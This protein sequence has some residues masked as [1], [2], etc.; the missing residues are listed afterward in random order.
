MPRLFST[1]TS[2]LPLSWGVARRMVSVVVVLPISKNTLRGKEAGRGHGSVY[3]AR[4][5]G[6]LCSPPSSPPRSY[7]RRFS[8]PRPAQAPSSRPC[9][10]SRFPPSPVVLIDVLPVLGP[11]HVGC[12]LAQD[13][14][15][16]LH[17][18]AFARLRV[19]WSLLNFRRD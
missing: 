1:Y 2:Y 11:A 6:Q 13:L 18:G 10:C 19:I 5:I 9:P 15:S 12:W 14:C 16:Q 8:W 4:L 17:R 7:F 3:W